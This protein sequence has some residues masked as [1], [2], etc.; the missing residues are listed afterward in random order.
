MVVQNL[1]AR[2][3]LSFTLVDGALTV[4][5]TSGGDVITLKLVGGQIRLSENGVVKKLAQASVTSIQVFGGNGKDSISLQGAITAPATLFGEAGN[6]SLHGGGG[7]DSIN[8]GPGND[9]LDGGEGADTLTGAGGNDTATYADRTDDLTITAEGIANDGAPGEN[10]NVTTTIENIIGGSG[11]DS[12]VGNAANNLLL[13]GDGN[14]TLTGVKG[15]DTL[16]GQAGADNMSGGSGLDTVTYASRTANVTVQ[17]GPGPSTSGCGES[18]ENDTIFNDIETIIG[19]AGND[20]LNGDEFVSGPNLLLEGGPGNDGLGGGSGNDTLE[21]GPGNDTIGHDPGNDVIDGGDGIDQYGLQDVLGSGDATITLDNLANDGY[22]GETDNVMD[23][24]ENLIGHTGND[25]LIGDSANNVLDGFGGQDSMDGGAGDDLITS[26]HGNGGGTINGGDG[27]DTLGGQDSADTFNEIHGGA[28]DDVIYAD[29]ST[30]IATGDDGNDSIN[31]NLRTQGGTFDFSAASFETIQGSRGND[32][33]IGGPGN[34]VILGEGGDDTIEGNGG[35]DYIDGG[36]GD[37][38]L[39]GGDG[40]DVFVNFDGVIDP[41]GVSDSVDGG[42]GFNAAED[43][44]FHPGN[45]TL[46]NDTL[47]N[48]QFIYDPAPGVGA[49]PTTPLAENKLSA[50]VA[51]AQAEIPAGGAIINGVLTILGTSSADSISVIL[52]KSGKN[53]SVTE[54]TASA[55]FPLSSVTGISI[56]AG[57]GND[58]IALV[59]GNGTRA[60]PINATVAGGN[61]NDVIVGG[62]GNDSLA[63]GNGNDKLF[64]GAGDDFLNGG[65]DK[66][67]STPDGADYISGGPGNDSVVYSNRQDNLS[68]DISDGTQANDGA[69]G[70]GDNV[71]PDVENVFGGNGN[72]SITGNAAANVLSGGGGNDTIAAGDGNDKLIGGSGSDSLLGQGGINLFSM[73]DGVR[74]D[75]DA[76]APSTGAAAITSFIS[77]DVSVDFSIPSN[78]TI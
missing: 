37:D 28:G 50:L 52:D 3:F 8:G 66:Q 2:R 60:V 63:G 58:A 44:G 30:T 15:D 10:D 20:V 72:D 35:D 7:S 41:N 32:H 40:N 27:N 54:N 24:V 9:T 21:G 47:T 11:N 22:A 70:E 75:F 36:L 53:I 56:D 51:A 42:A 61:G 19:G 33:I 62:A 5:G 65:S 31:M 69:P 74:D 13:G 71:Q 43:G 78:K 17:L 46:P 67:T 6:D 48:I 29:N 12:I 59:K 39:S 23:N 1:E 14:D 25:T 77:G 49:A 73:A 76:P 16:D 38:S 68:I 4:T 18:G 26:S 45:P 64:G 57:G 34:E 55:S